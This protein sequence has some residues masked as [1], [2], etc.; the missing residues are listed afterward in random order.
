MIHHRHPDGIT[1]AVVAAAQAIG[2]PVVIKAA[3]AA[4]EHKSELG[5]VI[6]DVRT[7]VEAAA[8]AQRLAILSDSI[9]VEEMV[10]DG[11][12][13]ALIGVSVDPDFG[14]VLVLGAGGVLTE[15]LHDSASLLP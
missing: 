8:A 4:L 13:E 14:Q 1:P 12:A 10:R 7:A 6:V 11:V 9:L 2:F 3:G 15:L 5:G